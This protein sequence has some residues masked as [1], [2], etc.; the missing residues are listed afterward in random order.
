MVATEDSSLQRGRKGI[1]TEDSERRPALAGGGLIASN[2]ARVCE[3]S[4]KS[5]YEIGIGY[6]VLASYVSMLIVPGS[7][8]DLG[9]TTSLKWRMVSSW[10][11]VTEPMM[12]SQDT[13][14]CEIS[15][16]MLSGSRGEWPRQDWREN[17]CEMHILAVSVRGLGRTTTKQVQSGRA[18][19]P[20]RVCTF[21]F[22]CRIVG[23]RSENICLE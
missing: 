2:K 3:D 16:Q 7:M 23:I 10:C 4:C 12:E 15:T 19:P 6:M 13:S 11:S 20:S 5:G 14:I 21:Q 17:V 8:R 1:T 9:R 22:I 18:D